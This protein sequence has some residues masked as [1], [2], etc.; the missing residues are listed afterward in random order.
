MRLRQDDEN[1][2]CWRSPGDLDALVE[3]ELGKADLYPK[4]DSP[5]VDIERFIEKH[6][7]ARLD[8]FVELEPRIQGQ[9]V[10]RLGSP[11]LVQINK[12]YSERADE[13]GGVAHCR[14]RMTM[15]HEAMHIMLHSHLFT[16]DS[17]QLPLLDG[18]L[19]ASVDTLF[20]CEEIGIEDSP[21]R[22]RRADW[23]EI[24]ANKGMAALLMPKEHFMD[25]VEEVCERARISRHRLYPDTPATRRI[26]AR[27]SELLLV[28]KQAVSIRMAELELLVPPRQE[29]LGLPEPDDDE[30]NFA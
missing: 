18:D 29:Q 12:S 16:T 27:V 20:R 25:T 23:R 24:Q 19:G 22:R 28:S 14:V 13:D 30:D 9:T 5:V 3:Y 1:G 11:P 7:G 4:Q 17:S 2:R 10:F 26:A 15:A 21:R 6:L 8:Q